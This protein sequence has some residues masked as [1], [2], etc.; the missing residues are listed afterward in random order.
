MALAAVDRQ[1]LKT[2]LEIYSR[3]LG[4]GG[5]LQLGHADCRT[6]VCSSVVGIIQFADCDGTCNTGAPQTCSVPSPRNRVGYLLGD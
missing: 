1:H 6:L 5:G 2:P 4:C 3:P